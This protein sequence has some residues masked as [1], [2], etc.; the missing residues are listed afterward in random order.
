MIFNLR[1]LFSKSP[2]AAPAQPAPTPS[3]AAQPA[4]VGTTVTAPANAAAAPSGDAKEVEAQD[5]YEAICEIGKK[6]AFQPQQLTLELHG[7][8][9]DCQQS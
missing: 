7:V 1:M 2:A 5:V 4:P 3:T 9:D 6:N 8:C